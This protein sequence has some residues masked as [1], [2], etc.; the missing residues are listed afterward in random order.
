[1]NEFI[2]KN[3][4]NGFTTRSKAK[5]YMDENSSGKDIIIMHAASAGEFEQ[6]KPLLRKINKDKYFIIQT[7]LSPTIYEAESENPLFDINAFMMEVD[8]LVND[9]CTTST[10][11]S[12]LN[13]PQ[14][15]YMPDYDLYNSVKGFQEDYRKVLPG[16]EVRSYKEL[17]SSLLKASLEPKSFVEDYLKVSEELQ[18]KYYDIKLNQSTRNFSDFIIKLL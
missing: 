11:F 10:D 17:K 1:M 15:F 12:I 8:I 9:Y 6:L 4:T 7:F 5:K 2:R 16:Q 13:K 3:F 14:I 18:D